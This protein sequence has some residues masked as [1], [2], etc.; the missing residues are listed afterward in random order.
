MGAFGLQECK[1]IILRV[2]VPYGQR[3]DPEPLVP[4]K[5]VAGNR[6]SEGSEFANSGP[7]EQELY[8]RLNELDKQAH[9]CDV[10]NADR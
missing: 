3:W 7:D 1:S 6:R 9:H 2:K 10:Q 4:R 5:G 8:K